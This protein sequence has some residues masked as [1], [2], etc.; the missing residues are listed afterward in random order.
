MLIRDALT[1]VDDGK[2]KAS[3]EHAN[4]GEPCLVGSS[5]AS[6]SPRTSAEAAKALA[7]ITLT[8]ACKC[9]CNPHCGCE[10]HEPSEASEW[11]ALD[12]AAT[13]LLRDKAQYVIASDAYQRGR[14]E[15]YYDAVNWLR[16][17]SDAA[18]RS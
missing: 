7:T 12:E 14:S 2:G 3:S 18:R 8:M 16:A 17:K 5:P 9:S 6:G 1:E 11:R 15:A 10:C 13:E 4:E